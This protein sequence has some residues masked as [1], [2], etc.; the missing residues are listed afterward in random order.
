M[1]EKDLYPDIEKFLT[2]NKNCLPEYVG[3]ELALKRGERSLRA[4]VFGVSNGD[5]KIVHLCEGKKEMKHRSFGKVVG[6]ALELLKYAD[7]VYVFGSIERFRE[8]DLEDQISKCEKF[9]IGIL[10]V[11]TNDGDTEVKELHEP[12]RNNIAKLDK[13]EVLL[14]IFVKNIVSQKPIANIIFQAAFEYI[15]L[16]RDSEV[17][18]DCV[19][20]IDVYNSIFSDEQFKERVRRVVGEDHTLEDRDVRK[21]FQRSC[22]KSRYIWIDRRSDILYDKICFTEEGLERG[23]S[24]ILLM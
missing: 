15:N 22:T 24:P 1:Y 17:E 4:D 8:E 6:E 2:R 23:K 5:E 20:F 7:F 11:I 21:E 10:S 3:T 16:H 19:R 9:G 14:R 12:R 13:R 18:R